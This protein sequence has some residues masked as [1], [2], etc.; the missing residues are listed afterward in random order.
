MLIKITK[1]LYSVFPNIIYC[2]IVIQ[3]ILE[4]SKPIEISFVLLLLLLILL[5]NEFG[6]SG[7]SIYKI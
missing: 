2:T 4:I 3:P 1:I 5:H 7:I 6:K